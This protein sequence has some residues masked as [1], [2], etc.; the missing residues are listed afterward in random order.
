MDWTVDSVEYV[1]ERP[2]STQQTGFSFVSQ[3]RSWL[4]D[5]IGGSSLVWRRRYLFHLLHAP[6]LRYQCLPKSYT[7]GS[8]QKFSWESA[9]WVFNFVANFANLKYSYMKPEIQAVQS[10]IEGDYL[11]QPV[12]DRTAVD[13]Y[14]PTPRGIRYLTDY[15]V[16]HAEQVVDRWRELGEYLV[17][18]YN[19]GYVKDEKGE[20]Q[21]VGYPEA[22]CAKC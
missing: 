13:L 2:I 20:P 18:K 4:P 17:M 3:S 19:D 8:L 16:W 1:W 11:F 7:V 14:R 10:R 22:G 15:S 5:P 21:E 6:L 12:V 9:W